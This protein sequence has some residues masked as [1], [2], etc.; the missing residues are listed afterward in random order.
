[1]TAMKSP[2]YIEGPKARENFERFTSALLQVPKAETRKQA[3]PKR[4]ATA[5]KT[6]GKN[7]G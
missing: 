7:K 6:S 4:K 5:H 3:K 1:M 2:E